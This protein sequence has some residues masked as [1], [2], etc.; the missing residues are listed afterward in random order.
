[1]DKYLIEIKNGGD[2]ASCLRSIQSFLSSRTH[3]VTSVEWGCLE[4]ENKAWLIIKTSNKED[5]LRIIPAAYRKNA[6]IMK[7][8]KFTGKEI[9]ESMLGDPILA[10]SETPVQNHFKDFRG[11]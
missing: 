11:S 4:G 2:T 8:H 1:M 10:S 9:K 3:F 7:L 5:A 6:R